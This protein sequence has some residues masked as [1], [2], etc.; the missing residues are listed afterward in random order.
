L[1][2]FRV[3]SIAFGLALGAVAWL[4]LCGTVRWP[5]LHR[6]LPRERIIGGLIA[7]ACLVWAAHQALPMLEGG[8]VRYRIVV[9]IAVPVVAVL[10]FLHLDYL[11]TRATGGLL[12]LVLNHLLHA[13]FV[14]E[15]PMR[16]LFS[17]ICY[18]VSLAGF[19]MVGAPWR[20]RDALE[21]AGESARWRRGAC[22]AFGV[23]GAAF[24]LFAVIG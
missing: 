5:D 8:L 20:F 13:A 2:A 7:A 12:L 22:A 3:S 9:K 4:F 16:P 10:S 11:L 15:I 24:L 14:A 17:L 19:F 18:L 23:C 1:L 21:R 6:R